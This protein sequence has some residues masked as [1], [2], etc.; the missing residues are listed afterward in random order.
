MR[1][2]LI[3]FAIIAASATAQADETVR[4]TQEE[5]RRRNTY[6]GDVDGRESPELAEAVKRYQRRKGFSASGEIDDQTKRSLGLAERK[7]GE[8]PPKELEWPE[9]PVLRSDIK[10]DPVGESKVVAEEGG[11]APASVMPPQIAEKAIRESKRASSRTRTSALAQSSTVQS[12]S[13]PDSGGARSSILRYDQQVDAQDISQFVAH[14][15][16]TAAQNKL[17]AELCFYADR[18]RY[19]QNGV[20]DRR[21]VER[22]LRDYYL[23]WPK[24]HYYLA[25]P[26][27]YV[28]DPKHGTIVVV[29][30]VRFELKN[31][32]QKVKGAVE[33]RITIFGATSAPRIV[34]IEERRLRGM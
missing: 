26:I 31:G 18:V 12:A 29:C 16:K 20:L 21:I 11:V 6:F 19:Y 9:V 23:R 32:S 8:P 33:N 25:G 3:S 14:F 7:P 13:K 15:L 1:L 27:N 17:P 28:P 24:R 2:R 30:P 5:L 22:T 4:A 10:I 34:A